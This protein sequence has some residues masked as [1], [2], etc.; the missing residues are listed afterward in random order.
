MGRPSPT[1]ES[2]PPAAYYPQVWGCWCFVRSGQHFE[3]SSNL[4]MIFTFNP[5]HVFLISWCLGLWTVPW[6]HRRLHGEKLNGFKLL[7]RLQLGA[8]GPWRRSKI[9]INDLGMKRAIVC[10][11]LYFLQWKSEAMPKWAVLLILG[12]FPVFSQTVFVQTTLYCDQT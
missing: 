7:R 1:V 3:V 2:W 8:R 4:N 11:F 12:C 9:E 5:W 10:N 6:S